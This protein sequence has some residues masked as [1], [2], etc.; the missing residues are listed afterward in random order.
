MATDSGSNQEALSLGKVKTAI[1]QD[2]A[3]LMMVLFMVLLV[4]IFCLMWKYGEV[5]IQKESCEATRIV[6]K[7]QIVMIK[8]AVDVEQTKVIRVTSTLSACE[9]TVG[10]FETK[11]AS[12]TLTPCSSATAQR[13][14]A[15]SPTPTPTDAPS[16]T[17]TPTN[18]LIPPTDTP[19]PTPTD[20]PIPPPTDTPIPPPS[21]DSIEPRQGRNDVS[22]PVT[23]HGS[24]FFGT[25]T[26]TLRLGQDAIPIPI[27]YAT[28]SVLRGTVRPGIARG[29]YDLVVTN[30]D[31]QQSATLNG[32]YT[33]RY[34]PPDVGGI[35][36]TEGCSNADVPV[37]IQG[38]DFLDTPTVTLGNKRV[39]SLCYVDAS[40]LTG[41]V[42]AGIAPGVYPLAVTNPDGQSDSLPGAYVADDR[43]CGDPDT[44]ALESPYLVTFGPDAGSR[45]D[46]G[47]Q[48]QVIWFEVPITTQVSDLHVRIFDADTGAEVDDHRGDDIYDTEMRYTLHGATLLSTVTIG[49][50]STLNGDWSS[51]FGPLSPSE[52]K[53]AG[54]WYVFRLE[55]EGLGGSDANWYRVALSDL[56]H[57]NSIPCDVRMYADSLTLL[58]DYGMVGGSQPL[59][60]PYV[61]K[62]VDVFNLQTFGCSGVDGLI[63]SQTP[64]RTLT[65]SC[66][67]DST[68]YAVGDDEDEATWAVDFSGCTNG[69]TTYLGFTI[70][71]EYN[72]ALP[73]FTRPMR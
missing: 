14:D 4:A 49:E 35:T 26:A 20:T 7:T 61:E 59:F 47:Y 36:P 44:M 65:A 2:Q 1:E 17:P 5:V 48:E 16:S 18:T 31:G 55:V 63:S 32:A 51:L 11:V 56:P 3:R 23:I 46:T 10:A 13:T 30:P 24:H 37:T 39:T 6:E 38:D 68:V 58:L 53:L 72:Q 66:C 73:I 70:K 22:V 67:V 9:G 21:V 64:S 60:H 43:F 57:T 62:E 45:Y 34:P 54:G 42:P 12:L 29:A 8:R 40:T 28:G 33:A 25:P 52:G 50:S 27:A 41:I 19:A 69:D 71:D 15:P